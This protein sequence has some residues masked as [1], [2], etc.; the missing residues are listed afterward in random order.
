MKKAGQLLARLSF[1]PQAVSVTAS[2]TGAAS[3]VAGSTGAASALALRFD[4]PLA[5]PEALTAC[6][7]GL[8]G[9][10]RISLSR[11]SLSLLCRTCL[12]LLDALQALGR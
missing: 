5:L 2:V 4:A 12:S 1:K 3:V 10:H 11:T 9:F 6:L 7:F 8:G